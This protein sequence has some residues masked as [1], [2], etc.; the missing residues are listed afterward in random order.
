[1][2]ANRRPLVLPHV[3]ESLPRL[4]T[5]AQAAIGLLAAAVFATATAF[6]GAVTL[7]GVGGQLGLIVLVGLIAVAAATATVASLAWGSG[8]LSRG[9]T[10]L[11]LSFAA[12][13]S[14]ATPWLV[15]ISG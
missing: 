10:V 14:L 4:S 6:F 5:T 12:L 3:D 2:A 15:M 13:L 1:M 9:A 8:R 7:A 11:Y